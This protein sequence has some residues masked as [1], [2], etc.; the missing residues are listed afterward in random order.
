MDSNDTSFETC[1]V[2]EFNPKCKQDVKTWLDKKL[3][4]LKEKNGAELLTKF[5]VNSK[6]EVIIMP[7]FMRF[8]NMFQNCIQKLLERKCFCI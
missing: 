8:L 4:A 3:R 5:T 7:G 6:N 2:I 1:V